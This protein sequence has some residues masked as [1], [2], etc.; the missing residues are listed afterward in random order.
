MADAFENAWSI[1][2]GEGRICDKINCDKEAVDYLGPGNWCSEECMKGQRAYD[3][4]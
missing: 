4:E 3:G 1:T 2:K